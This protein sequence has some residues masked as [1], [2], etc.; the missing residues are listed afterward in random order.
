MIE[1]AEELEGVSGIRAWSQTRSQHSSSPLELALED[2]RQSSAYKE[3]LN[4]SGRTAH[5]EAGL[6]RW[7]MVQPLGPV[8]AARDRCLLQGGRAYLGTWASGF[9]WERREAE[10][11]RAFCKPG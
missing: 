8:F 9:N 10:I 4:C 7:A 2:P 11:Y 5:L 3:H 1:E 6:A